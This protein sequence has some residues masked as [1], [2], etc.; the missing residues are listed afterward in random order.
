MSTCEH[1]GLDY[2]DFRTGYTYQGVLSML[3]SSSDDPK[4]WRYKGRSAVLGYWKELKQGLFAL[5]IG[6]CGQSRD[7]DTDSDT[8]ILP[9]GYNEVTPTEAACIPF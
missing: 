5:H 2:S 6:Y 7:A 4:Q 1:C 8:S 3:W 9:M